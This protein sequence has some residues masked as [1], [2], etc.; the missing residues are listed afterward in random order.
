V[1][2]RPIPGGWRSGSYEVTR[3]TRDGFQVWVADPDTGL[4]MLNAECDS[5]TS[6]KALAEH[7][8]ELNQPAETHE[9]SE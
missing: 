4:Q 2:W 1:N 9:G 8:R 6:A 3:D 5:A 7:H